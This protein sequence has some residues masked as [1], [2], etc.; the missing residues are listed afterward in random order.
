VLDAKGNCSAEQR[1]TPPDGDLATGQSVT[2][3]VNLYEDPCPGFLV[4]VSGYGLL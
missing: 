3:Q 4:G 2:F 1:N